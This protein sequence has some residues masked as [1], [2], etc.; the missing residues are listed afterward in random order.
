M[1]G[2]G[3]MRDM[4]AGTTWKS[5]NDATLDQGARGYGRPM[6]A[7]PRA[8]PGTHRPNP[9]D[10]RCF[11]SGG[12]DRNMP[13]RAA[14]NSLV[15]AVTRF[16]LRPRWSNPLSKQRQV[17]LMAMLSTE[18]DPPLSF[19]SDLSWDLADRQTRI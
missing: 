12:D 17:Y 15:V 5:P 4:D 7:V 11:R 10:V 6:L 3:V 19:Q 1:S 13:R 9:T 18:A 16:D 8:P 2:A 14:T